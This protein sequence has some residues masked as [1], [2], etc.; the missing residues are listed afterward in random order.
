[1]AAVVSDMSQ[2][3][4]RAVGNALE[5]GEALDTL[6]GHGPPEFTAFVV[7]L[8]SIIVELASA[9]RLG[10][11]DVEQVLSSGAAREAFRRMV[12]A[13][14]GDTAAFDD[15]SRLPI[16]QLRC[17][18]LADADGYVARLD[19]LTVARACIGLGAGRERKGDAIDLAVGVVLQARVGDRVARGQPLAIVHANDPS[20]VDAAVTTLR[21]AIEIGESAIPPAALILERLGASAGSR[22]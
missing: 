2:P 15:R 6:E 8:A 10:R 20:R 21:S 22:A 5:I 9:G 11:S 13:Q 4:G 3:L 12:D 1:M 14:A 18:L 17:E 7:E 16:A 19:A